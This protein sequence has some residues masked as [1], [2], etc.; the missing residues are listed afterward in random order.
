MTAAEN[1]TT[2]GPE[3]GVA[4]DQ[5]SP[6]AGPPATI[7]GFRQARFGMSEEQVRRIREDFP[8]AAAKFAN[9]VRPYEMATVS[10]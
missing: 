3:Q 7:D 9:T 8:A 4:K 5:P 10:P 1:A 6:P 2:A